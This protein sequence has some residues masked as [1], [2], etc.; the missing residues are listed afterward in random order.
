MRKTKTIRE[1]LGSLSQVID[2][3]LDQLMKQGIRRSQVSKLAEE[4]DTADL[5][6]EHRETI[7]EEL[8]AARE[9]QTELRQQIDRLGVML[10]KSQD[11]IAFSHKHFRSAISS[12]LHLLGSESLQSAPNGSGPPRWKF[13]ALDQR[14][15]ADPSWAETM[16]SL[17]APRTEEQTFWEWR[18]SSP[19]RP[20]VFEDPG[21]VTDEVVQLHLEQRVV[22]RLLSHFTAQ[23]FVYHDLSRACMAQSTD[24][25]P[26][27]LLI[28]RLALYGPGAARLHEELV[29]ITARWVDPA[30]RKSKLSPYGR[31]A[32]THTLNLLDSALLE[33]PARVVPEV[34]IKQLQVAAPHDVKELLPHLEERARDYARDA[35]NKLGRRA[36]AESKTMQDILE[37]QR[38]HLEQTI[39]HFDRDIQIALFPED[40][41]KQAEANRRYWGKRMVDLHQE[42]KTEPDRI[43]ASYEMRAQRI[44]PV[45]L[46]YLWPVSR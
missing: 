29:P 32:E 9:R 41:R 20:V 31:E 23:G 2:N 33:R 11:A 8:E 24:A 40:E 26:R 1:E 14:A 45:G 13:P 42:L 27:V 17:R 38:K 16:D 36:E 12:A 19:I 15:G 3:R 18:Q 7:D 39:A 22:Q 46:V 30:I 4:I 35:E 25:I 28:G 6:E 44:E 43:R 21:V 10:E 5:E 37:T 34:V